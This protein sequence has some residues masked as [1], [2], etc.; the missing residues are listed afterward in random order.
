MEILREMVYQP[1]HW[2]NDLMINKRDKRVDGWLFMSGPLPTLSICLFY[3]ILV[4]VIG[5][6]YMK[7]RPPFDIRRLLVVYNFVQM[8]FSIW[9]CQY[10]YFSGWHQYYSLRCQPV[11]YS[12]DPLAKRM[13]FASW[14]YYMSK[15]T[16][17]FDT[18]FFVMR[19]KFEHVSTLHVVHHG[20]MPMSVWFGVKFTPGGHSTFFGLL[21]S[22]VHIIM[23]FYYMMAALGPSWHKYLW[24]KKYLTSLQMV[25]FICIFVHAFQLL[26][27][28]CDYPKAFSWWIGGHAVLFFFLFTDFYKKAYTHKRNKSKMGHKNGLSKAFFN[29]IPCLQQFDVMEHH[30][31]S[32]IKANGT[33]H[34]GKNGYPANGLIHRKSDSA[35]GHS[36]GHLNGYANGHAN[37]HCATM[38]N[39]H[40]NGDLH[41]SRKDK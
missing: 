41:G 11:D 39:G 2:Y 34:A 37:G 40:A 14:W 15:F 35:N 13:T 10:I 22:F 1:I 36:N 8:I 28:D 6:R 19:K 5:P 23:Y 17:F 25:Q 27:I 7:N 30:Q 21:N 3:V 16:E 26:F 20:V 31:D 4:K 33:T 9:L 29:S 38:H 12:D 18:I 24:W 32:D